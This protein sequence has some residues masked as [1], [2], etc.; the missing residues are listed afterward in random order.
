MSLQLDLA[1]LDSEQASVFHKDIAPVTGKCPF[2]ESPGVLIKHL[3]PQTDCGNSDQ[4]NLKMEPGCRTFFR[5]A[6]SD[7][8]HEFKNFH[9]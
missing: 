3:N 6:L 9:I 8:F 1:S 4:L 5:T 7:N 2:S